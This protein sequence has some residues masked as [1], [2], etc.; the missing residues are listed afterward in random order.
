MISAAIFDMDGLLTDSEPRWHQAELEVAA[1][2]GLQMTVEDLKKTMGVRM[3][4][5]AQIWYENTPWEGPTP[6]EVAERVVDRVIELGESAT[7]LPGVVDTLDLV[8]EAGLRVALCSSSDKRLIDAT[9]EQ[10]GLASRFELAH[11]A[12]TNEYG[13]PHP[14]PYL[15][16]AQG[17]GVRPSECLAFE[18]SLNGCISARAASMQVVAVPDPEMVDTSQFGF[19]AEVLVSLDDMTPS[20]LARLIR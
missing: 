12:E 2:I 1:E 15:E 17:I 13:K 20:M 14:M 5:V 6:A 3:V 19:C 10:L 16:T 7:C 8:E 4:E 18:D 9:L 11:S